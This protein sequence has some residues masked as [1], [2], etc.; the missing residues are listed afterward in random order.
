[1]R[2]QSMNPECRDRRLADR[3]SSHGHG[4]RAGRLPSGKGLSCQEEETKHAWCGGWL[5]RPCSEQGVVGTGWKAAGNWMGFSAQ[6][7]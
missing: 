4:R 6:R 5:S 2:P 7:S 1:M 3:P